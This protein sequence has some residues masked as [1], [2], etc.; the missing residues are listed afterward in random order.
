MNVPNTRGRKET[1]Q[2]GNDSLS[3]TE[4]LQKPEVVGYLERDRPLTYASQARSSEGFYAR[5]T[6][7]RSWLRKARPGTQ[8]YH[9]SRTR[10]IKR[11]DEGQA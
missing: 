4:L 8:R 1:F 11:N 3:I 10:V 5:E 2:Y 9:K 6:L 7:T